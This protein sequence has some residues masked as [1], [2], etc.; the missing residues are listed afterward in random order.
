MS[1]RQRLVPVHIET[2]HRNLACPQWL[3]QRGLVDD[4]GTGRVDQND[5]GFQ[6]ADLSCADD[7]PRSQREREM[8]ADHIR[9]TQQRLEFR[10]FHTFNAC[11]PICSR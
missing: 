8:N 4:R 1:G 11:H 5:A 10:A 3:E 2:R 7:S 6:P 9:R